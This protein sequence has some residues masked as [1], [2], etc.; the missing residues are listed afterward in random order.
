MVIELTK[1]NDN[2]SCCGPDNKST[3]CC[4]VEALVSVDERGQMVLPKEVRDKANIEPGDK[5]AIITCGCNGKI[6]VISLVPS[7]DFEELVK[8]FLGPM[9]GEIFQNK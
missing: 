1:K 2:D 7:K 9:M 5:L 3:P 8:K 6:N 4:S